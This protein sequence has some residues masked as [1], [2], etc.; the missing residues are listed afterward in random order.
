MVIGNWVFN[1]FLS[2][3]INQFLDKTKKKTK[4]IHFGIVPVN[5]I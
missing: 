5:L 2:F 3:K 1:R 4:K